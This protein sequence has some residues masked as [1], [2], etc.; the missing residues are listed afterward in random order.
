MHPQT[1]NIQQHKK[2]PLKGEVGI[3]LLHFVAKT[4]FLKNGNKKQQNNIILMQKSPLGDL[5][6]QH[7]FLHFTFY[8]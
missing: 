2:S 4:M 8:F 5:E 3:K 1:G 7:R 6:V